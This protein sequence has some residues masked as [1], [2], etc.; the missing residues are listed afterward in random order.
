[1]LQR[2][3]TP[4][5]FGWPLAAVLALFTMTALAAQPVILCADTYCPYNC[6]PGSAA[7][8]YLIE[9]AQAAMATRGETVE[10]QIMPWQRAIIST[11]GGQCDALVGT[12]VGEPAD[13]IF[14]AVEAGM[15]I[16]IF[17]TLSNSTWRYQGSAS[18]A[19][20]TLG[21]IDG[22]VYGEPVDS[23][24][25]QHL[26][27][28][29]R[30]QLISGESAIE[31]N[32]VLLESGRTNAY[33]EDKMVLQYRAHI[34]SIHT[35]WRIAG[36]ASRLPLH[37]AF[38]PAKTES[39]ARAQALAKVVISWRKSGKLRALLGRYGLGDWR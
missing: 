20:V 21:G 30:V 14:P 34:K 39:A 36:E 32:L 24:I 29:S 13:F 28:P 10:Y 15:N 6:E 11:R 19:E 38:S 31:Q 35:P 18:L 22:Y 26:H 23:W 8:G 2:S 25:A 9:L 4:A 16:N 7:P 37:I 33:I 17:I 3:I 12:P 5:T 1:M 27:Q